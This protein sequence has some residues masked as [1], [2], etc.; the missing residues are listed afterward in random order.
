MAE[1]SLDF[2]RELER[3]LAILSEELGQPPYT[4]RLGPASLRVQ[5]HGTTLLVPLAFE[6]HW[7]RFRTTPTDLIREAAR[8]AREQADPDLDPADL[9]V[10]AEVFLR[11][12]LLDADAGPD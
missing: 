5:L 11:R 12:H 3:L 8:L 2:R 9:E 10:F 7:R 4:V 1:L 6:Q